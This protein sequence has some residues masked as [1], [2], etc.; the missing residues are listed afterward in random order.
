MDP[1]DDPEARIRELERP[2]SDVARASELGV[3]APAESLYA[4]PPPMP[5]A[6]FG[7]SPGPYPGP[8]RST[9]SGSGGFGFIIAAVAVVIVA[10]AAGVIVFA[11]FSGTKSTTTTHSTPR[12]TVS[13]NASAPSTPSR[14]ESATPSPGDEP[15]EVAPPGGQLSVYGS[16]KNEN[17]ACN[18]SVVSVSGTSNTVA[19]TGHCAS[20][21]VSGFENVV[22]VDDVGTI[23]ASGFDNK[24]TYHSGSPTVNTS[25]SGNVVQQG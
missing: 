4:P 9:S 14:S 7:E 11:K 3:T 6:Y 22:T 23:Q 15:T 25:G 20:L 24:V 12:P 2:M 5:P 19:I 21:T 10:V 8:M 1:D 16:G 13:R 18:D 17:L